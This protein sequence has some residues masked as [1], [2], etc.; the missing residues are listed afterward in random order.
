MAIGGAH[1]PCGGCTF[2]CSESSRSTAGTQTSCASRSSPNRLKHRIRPQPTSGLVSQ[3]VG[4]LHA[5][6]L[7][8]DEA[9]RAATTAARQY[10]G[11]SSGEDLVTYEQDLRENPDLLRKPAA[12]VIRGIRVRAVEPGRSTEARGSSRPTPTRP[13]DGWW[14]GSQPAAQCTE[15][16]VLGCT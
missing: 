5:Y 11:D 6:G 9:L 8:V 2:T 14:G 16:G 3:A 7:T 12:A 10:L 4:L 13:A 15:D 1:C